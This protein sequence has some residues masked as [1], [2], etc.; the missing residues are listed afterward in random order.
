MKHHRKAKDTSLWYALDFLAIL[1]GYCEP[2]RARKLL[3]SQ[4][5]FGTVR[6]E[7]DVSSSRAKNASDP[8]DYDFAEVEKLMHVARSGNPIARA[9]VQHIRGDL[10]L[11]CVPLPLA[12]QLFFREK[13]PSTRGRP[14]TNLLQRNQLVVLATDYAVRWGY[15]ITR[16]RATKGSECACSIVSE[17][18]WTFGVCLTEEAIEKIVVKTGSERISRFL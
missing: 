16:E 15:K 5:I 13:I 10:T 9:A 4:Y 18:L 11:R 6:R 8:L 12:L 2:K 7:N 14:A 1:G 17:K 3:L